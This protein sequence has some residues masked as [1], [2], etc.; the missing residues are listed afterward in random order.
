MSLVA[1]IESGGA[2]FTSIQSALN[3]VGVSSVV[4]RDPTQIITASHVMLPGVGAA[5]Y[6]MQLLHEQGLATLIPALRQPVLGIC[7]GQQLLCTHSEEDDADCL[8]IIPIGVARIK[9]ARIIPHMGWNNV[10]AVKPSALLKG[11]TEDQDFYFVHSYAAAVS[12]AFTLGTCDYGTPFSAVIHKDNF[13]GV[14]FHPEKSGLAGMR[15]L[16]NFVRLS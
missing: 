9:D 5:G 14:Q 10:A 3:R 11:I 15:V 7:L 6:G 12:P 4:T 13:Y 8:G 2:N 16:E 1:I